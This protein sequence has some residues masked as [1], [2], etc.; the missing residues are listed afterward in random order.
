M[1]YNKIIKRKEQTRNENKSSFVNHAET[2]FEI[3][4]ESDRAIQNCRFCKARARCQ[5]RIGCQL[6]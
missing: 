2:T 1:F 4:R 6:G 5:P 3:K